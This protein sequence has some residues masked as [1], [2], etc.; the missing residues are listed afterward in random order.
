MEFPPVFLSRMRELLGNDYPAFV[1]ALSTPSPTSVRHHPVKSSR[2]IDSAHRI[3]W[4]E[5]GEYLNHRPVFTLDPLYHAGCYYVQEASSMILEA[6]YKSISPTATPRTILDLCAAPGGKAT[7]LRALMGDHDILVANE[8]HPNRHAILFE[9]LTRWGNPLTLTS[10]CSADQLAAVHPERFDIILVDAPC[11]GEGMFR[12]DPVA[13]HQWDMDLVYKCVHRQR[14]IL[15]DALQLLRPG[16]YLIYSTCTFNR[17]ENEDQ[18]AQLIRQGG[19]EEVRAEIDPNWGICV[20]DHGIRCYPHLLQGE[21]IYMCMIRKTTAGDRL[22]SAPASRGTNRHMGLPGHPPAA[23]LEFV[24]EQSIQWVQGKDQQWRAIPELV[25]QSAQDLINSPL[26]IQSGVIVGKMKTNTVFIPDH[27]LA[28]SS[29]CSTGVARFELDKDDA[30]RFLKKETIASS[31]VS[32]GIRLISYQGQGLG[33]AK[34]VPG[35]LN[36]LIPHH[37]RIRM[38]IPESH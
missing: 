4:C 10:R 21:G 36:N 8:V 7:H 2:Q 34:A 14:E 22:S 9:N 37:W 35:R 19:C 26:D 18:M 23:I 6:F 28:L 30:L 38:S 5:N 24:D 11:S 1:D 27:A 29:M 16:G 15:A 17:E 25:A 33:W 13:V 20:S 31:D 32:T 3:P 12:K